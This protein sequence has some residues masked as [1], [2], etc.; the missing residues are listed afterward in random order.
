MCPR[1]RLN[2]ERLTTLEARYRSFPEDI[3]NAV[4]FARTL[5]AL[6]RDK[7]ALVVMTALPAESLG[8]EERLFTASMKLFDSDV[9]GAVATAAPVILPALAVLLAGSFPVLIL[10]ASG[11][12][13][14][15]DA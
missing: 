10:F 2:L 7:P 12:R 9:P 15:G 13:S 8:P 14:G 1:D 11:R 5:H 3:D 6:R 4:D